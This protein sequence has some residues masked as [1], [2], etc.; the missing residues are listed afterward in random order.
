MSGLEIRDANDNVVFSNATRNFS[1]VRVVQ[2]T[3]T[4]N[5]SATVPFTSWAGTP[6]II[7]MPLSP[8]YYGSPP[9]V[10]ISGNTV[11]WV[12]SSAVGSYANVACRIVCGVW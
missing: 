10:T 2:T 8:Q 11:S 9:K 12:F 5:G 4:S 7:V 6:Q 1:I 3:G